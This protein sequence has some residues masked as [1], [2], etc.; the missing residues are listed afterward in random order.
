MKFFRLQRR[1][2]A[3]IGVIAPLLI[4]FVYVALRS[5][6]LAPVAVTATSVE[7]RSI[8]PALFGIG[9]VDARYTY[10]IGPTYPGRIVRLDVH[11]GDAVAAG[12]LLGAMDPVD[13]GQR[14][15][16][17]QAALKGGEAVLRQAEAR[18]AFAQAQ[19]KRYD[20]LLATHVT[21]EE[22]A[23]SKRQ[24]LAVAD[25]ALGA[26]REDIRRLR[27]ELDALRAQHANLNLMAPVAG[28]V[29]ARDA[30]PGTTVV[31]GQ[32]VIELI[33]PASLWIDARFD[34]VS[35]E[36]LAAG[37][38]AQIVLRSRRGERLAGRVLRL[39]PRAD[40]VTEETLAK[41]IFDALPSPLP[42]L[43]ELAEVTVQLPA[44]PAAPTIPNAAV[45]TVGGRRGVW[46]L[47]RGKPVFVPVEL[48][49][50]DL[51]GRV[52]VEKGLA[53]GDRIVVYSEKPLGARSRIHVVDRIAGAAP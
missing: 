16:A 38:P 18:Q 24:E 8:T 17:Q 46:K 50:F 37:L 41:I 13:L 21:S 25:A 29:V 35:A 6:P 44:L 53:A 10:K 47:E 12:Q 40:L 5:G 3:L 1:T 20:A 45:H 33:D 7:P 27:A 39:E 31:A 4:L 26:A 28:L 30:D 19:A 42:P 14:I 22:S 49:R 2:L 36:G 11:V 9:A 15:G 51:D 23:A 43:G 48:G 32:A 52:Q 34:Q